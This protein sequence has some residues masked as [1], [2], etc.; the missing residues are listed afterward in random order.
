MPSVAFAGFALY[1]ECKTY[2]VR[3]W[4]RARGNIKRGGYFPLFFVFSV[5]FSTWKRGLV[6]RGAIASFG[7]IH[8]AISP[9]SAAGE[10]VRLA[11][12]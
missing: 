12:G 9:R 4:S 7:G 3:A 5:L 2:I 10:K 11:A 6:G 8:P 1:G